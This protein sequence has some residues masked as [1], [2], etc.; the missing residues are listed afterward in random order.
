MPRPGFDQRLTLQL[1]NAGIKPEDARIKALL[2]PRLQVLATSPPAMLS[3]DTLVWTLTAVPSYLPQTFRIDAILDNTAQLGSA[4]EGFAWV[5]MTSGTDDF[6]EN[7][8]DTLGQTIVGSYDPNDKTAL[9]GDSVLK[10]AVEAGIRL[11]YLIR[12]Q[13]TGTYPA[14]FVRI[15][16]TLETDF[17]PLTFAFEG[18]SHPVRVRFAQPRVLEFFFDH[19][20]LPDSTS[21]EPGSHGFVRYSIAPYRNLEVGDSLENRAAIYFDY[22]PPVITNT[23]LTVVSTGLGAGQDGK[24]IAFKIHPNPVAAGNKATAVLSAPASSAIRLQLFDIA[25][26]Q[27]K[28]WV[29]PAGTL[30][31]PLPGL[32]AGAYAVQ[33]QMGE[34]QGV[35]L[36][37]VE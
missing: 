14:E 28:E 2:D 32:A 19:I 29:V 16:D 30:Q 15:L 31:I 26:R 6:P 10:T 27:V 1:L 33:V 23:A 34:R 3:G 5:E 37:V 35:R 7:N 24:K 25:G 13:N 22:N 20:Q 18:A 21:D 4:L 9:S 12:F 8:A 36:L 17:D 11:D